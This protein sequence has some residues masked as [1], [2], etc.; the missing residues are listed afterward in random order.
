M[1]VDGSLKKRR[2]GSSGAV[3]KHASRI[4]S[5]YRIVGNVSTGVPYAIGTLGTTFYIVTSVGKS[6]QIFDANNLHLLFVSDKETDG[7]ITCLAAHFHYVYA[8]FK[9]KVGIY[10]RG[11]L[12]HLIELPDPNTVVTKINV[13]GEYLIASTDN[14]V[15]YIYKKSSPSDKFA[16]ELYTNFTI[17]KLQGGDIVDL[18]HLPTYVNKLL[19]VTKSNFILFNVR[20]GKQLYTSDEFPDEITTAEPAPALDIV[21]FGTASGEV[22]LFNL[23]KAKKIRTIKTPTRISSISFRTD[24]A[25]HISV[26]STSGDLIFYDLDHRSRIQV[27]KGIHKEVNGGVARASFLNGQ[28]IVVTC[29]GDNQLKEFVFDPSLSQGDSEVVIQPAR[30]LRSRGGHSQPPSSIAF[31]DDQSHFILSASKD[32]SLWGFSLRKDAQSQELSQRLHK[33]KDGNRIGGSTIGEKFPEITSIAIENNRQGQWENI[34]TVHKGEKFART[35]NSRT[36]RVGRWTIPTNDEGFAKSVAISQCGNF[37]LVGSSNGGISVHNLQSGQKR[38]VYRLHKKAVTGIAMDGMNRKMV[39]CGLDGIVGF[40]DFSKSTFL[41]KLQ[42]DSPITSMVYHR[43]SDLF[44]LALDDLSIVVIDS[45]TQ[46]V[47]RQLWGHSNRISSFD[48]SPDGRWIISSSLD[49]TIRTWDLPTGGCIDGMKVENVITNIKFS[50]NGDLLATTSVSGNGISLWANRAQFVS[51]STRQIDEEEFATVMLPNVSG[52]GGSNFL[53]GAFDT[54]EDDSDDLFG[55][56]DSMEQ[57]DKDLLTLSLGPRNKMNILLNLDI[58]KQRSKPKEAP[59]KPEQA[60][61]FL[62]LAKDKVG[63]EASAREGAKNL[64]LD[65]SKLQQELDTAKANAASELNKF[66]PSGKLGAQFESDFTKLLREG[67]QKNDYSEFLEELVQMTPSNIDLEIRSL[68]AFQPFDELCWFIESLAQGLATNKNFELYEAYIT[69]LFRV[70]GDV[71]HSNNT[72]QN[73]KTALQHW[74]TNHR[75]GQSLDE[76]VKICGSV[77]SFVST[78]T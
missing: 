50:P 45:V 59:V 20:T 13:F 25:S 38:K 46:K 8:S 74:D 3:R 51:V 7:D 4:F 41:G 70:H 53:E 19:V 6:F 72:N 28:P 33:N 30:L 52:D 44:A 32:R 23:R 16:T 54:V 77:L 12:E 31:A 34:L 15:V 55:K 69:I 11:K 49:S 65:S 2:V 24:G 42:L 71:I 21:A 5:P 48:F 68:N 75:K 63:D 36:K 64:S 62:Q 58:I 26:A 47:V 61:F 22:I 14:K 39:S 17:G 57:I 60:P 37:G 66:K 73:I 67:W 43:T 29:G 18:V 78:S 1:T 40:Y 27:L 76:L 35:W 9:N 10:K 56:Y